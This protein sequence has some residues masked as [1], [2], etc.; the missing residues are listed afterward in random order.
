LHSINYFIKDNIPEN[1]NCYLLQKKNLFSKNYFKLANLD[2]ISIYH[3]FLLNLTSTTINI[4]I[5]DIVNFFA[6]VL[7]DFKDYFNIAIKE[8]FLLV[9]SSLFYF[10]YIDFLCFLEL[11]FMNYL[12]FYLYF[13]GNYFFILINI[14]FYFLNYQIFNSFFFFFFLI[15]SFF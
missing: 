15:I 2:S 3:F 1:L 5:I 8:D 6:K 7:K 9:I 10:L 11:L 12:T 4:T 14:F 13:L